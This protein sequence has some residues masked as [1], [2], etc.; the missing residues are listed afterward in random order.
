[1]PLQNGATFAGYTVRRLL[2]SGGMGE[3]YLVDHPRLPRYDA[4]KVLRESATANS[5]FRTRFN[6]EAEHAASLFHP[7][8]VGLHDRGEFEGRLWITMDYVEGTDA[9]QLLKHR[10]PRGLPLDQVVAIVSAVGSAL[11]YAHQRGLLHRDIKPA[12]LLLGD[13]QGADRRILLSDFGIARQIGEASGLTATNHTIGTVA[14]SAPE[15]LMGHRIDGRADQYSLAA[16]AFRLLT[17]ETPYRESNQVAV[18]SQHLNAPPPRVSERRAELGPLDPVLVKAMAKNPQD[19]FATCN[20]FAQAFAQQ[21]SAAK[22]QDATTVQ[23]PPRR[24][25]WTPPP[26]RGVAPPAPW[27]PAAMGP[28]PGLLHNQMAF[29]P[30]PRRSRRWIAVVAGVV[31]VV[32]VVTGV[33]VAMNLGGGDTAADGSS[34][35][36]LRPATTLSRPSSS[37]TTTA[38]PTAFPMPTLVGTPGNYQTIQTYIQQSGIEEQSQHRGDAKAPTIVLPTPDGWRDAGAESPNFAYQT[39]LYEGPDAPDSRPYVMVIVSKLVGNV[40]PAKVFAAAPGEL[41]NLAGWAPDDPGK[42]AKLDGYPEF[43]L[44]GQWDSSGKRTAVTQKTVLL[45]W[46][47]GFYVL[48]LNLNS[49]PEYRPILDRMI[50]AIDT[51]AR[52]DPP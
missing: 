32:L 37:A 26:P 6:R 28:P 27:P 33:V 38:M 42:V 12:N 36:T 8:I 44:S 29:A 25:G 48:Q 17:G 15:Q 30:P 4:L 47:Q 22:A 2:G 18:I 16:S 49:A 34:T 1:M 40:D 19:R 23:V 10:Y 21:A 43:E 50:A 41:Y 35:S 9:A 7:H 31:A 52:I 14:Y 3:V 13:G 46:K 5:D 11:D 51:D 20:E 45:N 24:S 39:L